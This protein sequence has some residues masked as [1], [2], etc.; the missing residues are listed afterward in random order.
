MKQLLGVIWKYNYLGKKPSKGQLIED[1]GTCEEEV[2]KELDRL[3]KEGLIT[4]DNEGYDLTPLGRENLTVVAC[5][6][7]FDILHPGHAFIVSEARKL[8]D[9]LVVIVAR[10]S[11]VKGRKR[12]PIVPEIQRA[13][14]VG[15]LKGVGLS[16]IGYPGDTLRI[17]EEI[18]PDIIA[19]G[20]DQ[21]HDEDKIQSELK[22]RGLGTVV[23]RIGEFKD[24]ELNSTKMILQRIIERNYPDERRDS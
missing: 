6:G 7:V 11:T 22:R 15:S 10:D 4:M 5:G 20:P 1:R 8:G 16:V 19:L 17:I 12:I 3:I 14:M 18:S 13:E 21:H 23:K 24:C 9:I 2:S